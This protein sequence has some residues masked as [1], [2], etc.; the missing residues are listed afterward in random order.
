MKLFVDAKTLSGECVT[1]ELTAFPED[2]VAAIKERAALVEPSPFPEQKLLREG[3]E[4]SCQKRLVDLGITDGD[5][6]AF[7]A[8]A[9]EKALVRQLRDLLQGGAPMQVEEVGLMY[10]LK[11]GAPIG[12]VLHALGEGKVLL[13]TFLE[14]HSKDFVVKDGMATVAATEPEASAATAMHLITVTVLVSLHLPATTKESVS[15]ELSVAPHETVANLKKRAAEAAQAPCPQEVQLMLNGASLA[16]DQQ[17]ASCGVTSSSTLELAATWS[18]ELLAKQLVE[19]LLAH[20]PMSRVELDNMHCCRFGISATQGVQL[21]GWEEKLPVKEMLFTF[22]QRRSEDFVVKEGVVTTAAS[23]REA[24]AAAAMHL[25]TVTVLVSLHLP[26]MI[27]SSASLKLSVAPHETVASLRKRAA[28]AAQAPSPQ[29]V[30]LMLEGASLAEDH[31]L[32]AC[33][34]TSSSTLE[35][36]AMWSEQLLAKQ[37]VEVLLAHGP[38]SR[39]ELDNMH[40]CRFGVSATQGVQ[41]LGWGEKL[42]AFLARQPALKC[43]KGGIALACI[44]PAALVAEADCGTNQAFLDLHACLCQGDFQERVAEALDR[45]ADALSRGTFLNVVEVIKG[46]AAAAGMAVPGAVGAELTLQLDGMPATSQEA[47]LP[48]LVKSAAGVLTETLCGQ[49]EVMEVVAD[50]PG[51]RLRTQGILGEVCVRFAPAYDS[52][53]EAMDTLGA[54][55]GASQAACAEAAFAAQRARFSGRL[56]QGVKATVQLLTWWREQQHWSSDATRP[57]LALLELVAAHTVAE[58]MP[59]NL[60]EAVEGTLAALSRFDELHITTWPMAVRSYRE[61]DLWAPL[62]KQT[63]LVTHPGNPFAN[64]AFSK[65]F[66]PYELVT[67]A[68]SG[69]RI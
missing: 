28:E 63:P 69:M 15:L 47:W 20:G 32:A 31:Q 66:Q 45:L 12:D 35:L 8:D 43:E 39:V 26:A 19:V 30:Q 65:A 18:E 46:G 3:K 52:H 60:C 13:R 14:R 9:S 25:I 7:Q 11:H 56:S 48:G 16:D 58:Q 23:E 61:A 62:R 64:A 5:R 44:S 38:M 6:L 67:C 57:S 40:C 24:R 22:L 33:G 2:T 4:L 10:A 53:G 36:V 50:G 27:K 17:L 59:S 51:L 49:E 68:R 37:L 42:Q 34:V 21:L 1:F 55:A 54:M 29:A 41:L